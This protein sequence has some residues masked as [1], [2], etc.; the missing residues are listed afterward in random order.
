MFAGGAAVGAVHIVTRLLVRYIRVRDALVVTDFLTGIA[1]RRMLLWRLTEELADAKRTGEPLALLYMDLDGFKRLND[2]FG[3][4]AGDEAL[5]RIA[6]ALRDIVRAHDVVARVGG[7]E[8]VIMAPRLGEAEAAELATRLQHTVA[9]TD[10]PMPLGLSVGWVLATRDGDTPEALLD[11]ADAGLFEHKRL[12]RQVGHTLASEL[13]DALRVL[14]DGARHL[15]RLLD[16]QDVDLEVEEHLAQVGYWS[17]E[18]A[19]KV[20]LSMERQRVLAQA[21]L[22]HDVGKLG[23]PQ[24]L[25][26]KRTPLTAQERARL[27]QHVTKG[28]ALLR[29]LDVD[30][31]VISIVAAHHERW[32]GTGYPAKLAGEAIP[33]EA[34]ILALADSYDAMTTHRVYHK[35]LSREMA[36]TEL[37]REANRQF[38]PQLVALLSGL[39]AVQRIDG[40]ATEMT[41][42]DRSSHFYN[43][44]QVPNEARASK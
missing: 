24:S 14:P 44:S 26:L 39:L 37:R 5:V 2:K 12:T 8:F 27:V 29:T 40:T 32:D 34:R 33:L 3:H 16:T 36:T 19:R 6:G 30:E 11:Q 21:A 41:D 17:L 13:L 18:L 9:A 20:G 4:Q 1:N 22:L 25:L 35:A 43:R 38:D 15:V 42:T 31:A 7:D 23:L 10:L 28:V